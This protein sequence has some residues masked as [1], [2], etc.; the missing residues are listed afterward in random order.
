M[1]KYFGYINEKGQAVVTKYFS[2]WDVN[3]LKRQPHCKELILPFQANNY[4]EAKNSV[5]KSIGGKI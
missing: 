1:G 3:N 2:M 5:N 4:E